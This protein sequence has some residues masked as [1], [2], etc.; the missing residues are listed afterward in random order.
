MSL[1]ERFYGKFEIQ[2]IP[3][4]DVEREIF[5]D[6]TKIELYELSVCKEHTAM[7]AKK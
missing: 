7:Q 1:V 3:F 5:W 2:T 6:G 4:P